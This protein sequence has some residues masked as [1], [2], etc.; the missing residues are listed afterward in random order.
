[1]VTMN[2]R[3][4]MIPMSEIALVR[5][6]RLQERASL[7]SARAVTLVRDAD[8]HLLGAA[9]TKSL[10][11]RSYAKAGPTAALSPIAVTSPDATLKE[12][13]A[14]SHVVADLWHVVAEKG[15]PVGVISPAR[16][17]DAAG[18]A[19]GDAFEDAFGDVNQI[20]DLCLCCQAN[21][22]HCFSPAEA[23][24]QRLAPRAACPRG[25]GTPLVLR[26]PCPR[27]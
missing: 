1:M 2:A 18:D 6:S 12:L 17:L 20:P 10:R 16:L 9:E 25:D 21:P 8:D 27:P 22:S 26:N 24:S 3:D 14:A 4:L 15:R 7:D 19:F 11:Q 5:S 23:R 13:V